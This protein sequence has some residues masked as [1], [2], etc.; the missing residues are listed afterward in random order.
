VTQRWRE[1]GNKNNPDSLEAEADRHLRKSPQDP[2]FP[3]Y[4]E[5]DLE[6]RDQRHGERSIEEM[7]EAAE[8]TIDNAQEVF[9]CAWPKILAAARHA[10]CTPRQVEFMELHFAGWTQAEIAE[11]TDWDQA[12]VSRDLKTVAAV[13]RRI[14][15]YW[16]WLTIAE[17]F[18]LSVPTVRDITR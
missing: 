3:A 14:P 16:V 2:M 17:V 9:A 6:R 15:E 8:A 1:V 7:F 5:L 11:I 10:R 18:S 13:M 4:T 12:T